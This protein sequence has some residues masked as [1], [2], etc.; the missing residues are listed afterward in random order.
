MRRN[1]DFFGILFVFFI[2]LLSSPHMFAQEKKRTFRDTLDYKLDF[3]N[4]LINMHGFVP[5][6]SIISEPALGNF[7]LAMALV[8]VSPK[9]SA[10]SKDQY[11]FPDI[12]A[13]A[14]MYTLNNTWGGGAMRQGTFPKIGM[15]YTIGVGYVDAKMDFYRNIEKFGEISYQFNLKPIVAAIDISENLWRNKIFIGLRYEFARMRITYDFP[16]LPD[17]VFEPTNFDKNIGNLSLYGEWDSRNSIF[18]PDKGLRFKAIGGL[19]RNWTASSFDFERL[20]VFLNWF[21]QPVR[22]WVC[23]FRADVQSLWGNAPFYYYPYLDMRGIAMM[24]YQG[25]QTLLFETEQRF[26]VTRRWSVLGFVG[27]GRTF[28]TSKYMKDDS[29][30]VAG[31]V[32]F[33]YLIARLFRMRMGVDVAVG[34]DQFAYYIVL[35]HYW[36][37]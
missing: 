5:Y 30:H 22:F 7:G 21:I 23:G 13:V 18:T 26:N 8:F 3:S 31:G 10:S 19:G 27:T 15:R 11:R 6:P 25:Q 32:G 9:K 28:S 2:V 29:W 14:G 12:T 34:P 4:Y 36:N 33:R 20:E 37:R 1:A 24:R 16:N 17:S 35:G